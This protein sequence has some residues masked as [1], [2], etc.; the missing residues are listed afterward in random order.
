MSV[1]VDRADKLTVMKGDKLLEPFS[2]IGNFKKREKK[3]GKMTFVK[4]FSTTGPI[5]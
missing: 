4:D 5:F 3:T 1:R 2:L